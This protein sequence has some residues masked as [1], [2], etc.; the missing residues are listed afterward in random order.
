M[1][2]SD[3]ARIDFGLSLIVDANVREDAIEAVD[4]LTP[5]GWTALGQGAKTGYAE[6][7]TGAPDNR[8]SMV[9]L[10][11]ISFVGALALQGSGKSLLGEVKTGPIPKRPLGRTGEKLSII[12]FGGIVVSK[13]AQSTADRYVSETIVTVRQSGGDASAAIPGAAM[14]LAG[15]NPP[16]HEDT[17]FVKEFVHSLG[18]LLKLEQRLQLREHFAS[19]A[20]DWP[21]RLDRDADNLKACSRMTA[22]VVRRFVDR[23]EESDG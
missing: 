6:V 5:Y 8:W 10:A 12:G 20:A 2:F 17:L 22:G 16:A 21:Y 14:L 4:A 23:R 18:L 11:V 13:E 9:L 1:S 19:P 3:D 15:V 7:V